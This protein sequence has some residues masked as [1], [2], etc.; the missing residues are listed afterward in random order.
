MLFY[1]L[2]IKDT[3]ELIFIFH[4]I[5]KS[6]ILISNNRFV[7]FF[8]DCDLFFISICFI[9]L[10]VFFS[11]SNFIGRNYEILNRIIGDVRSVQNIW[12]RL[13][14]LISILLFLKP[15]NCCIALLKSFNAL[16][17]PIWSKECRQRL[18]FVIRS[19][20]V[21]N[22]DHIFSLPLGLL[23][24]IILVMIVLLL[25]VVL[26]VSHLRRL[27]RWRASLKNWFTWG[28]WGW[29]NESSTIRHF[30]NYGWL[31]RLSMLNTLSCFLLLVLLI[32]QVRIDIVKI[33]VVVLTPAHI[34]GLILL[35][36]ISNLN[37][38][39]VNISRTF[40]IINVALYRSINNSKKM[41]NKFEIIQMSR[42]DFSL[43][44]RNHDLPTPWSHRMLYPSFSPVL[45]RTPARLLLGICE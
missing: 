22:V 6:T 4:Q 13:H 21:F 27:I 12:L 44:V 38:Y 1:K 5:Q 17:I 34:Q 40:N 28:G 11:F 3:W 25:L 43:H 42:L 8:H 33:I 35:L 45:H 19:R 29:W 9:L 30:N 15:N 26:R 41:I 23:A 31:R 16:D 18:L 32:R 36:C 24:L 20:D 10:L 14:K 2:S 7:I 37:L 39:K